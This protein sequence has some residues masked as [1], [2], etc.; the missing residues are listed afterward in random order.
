MSKR[1]AADANLRGKPVDD[2]AAALTRQRVPFVF[3][4]G[5][6]RTSLPGAFA[7]SAILPKPFTDRQLVEAVKALLISQ[8]ATVRLG[9]E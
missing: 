6:G 1:G 3:V 9:L 2:I 8:A 7:K 5:Y 4:T